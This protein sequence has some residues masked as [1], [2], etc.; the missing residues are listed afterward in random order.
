[1]GNGRD[2]ARIDTDS[3][4]VLRSCVRDICVNHRESHDIPFT[5]IPMID[6]M[7]PCNMNLGLT[8]YFTLI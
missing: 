7:N 6:N 3:C 1:M 8:A 2:I 5:Q 4:G